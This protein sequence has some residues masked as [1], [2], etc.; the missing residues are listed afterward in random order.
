MT[1]R[2]QSLLSVGAW[3]LLSPV[4]HAQ[5]LALPPPPPAGVTQRLGAQLPLAMP[6]VDSEG[7]ALRLGALFGDGRP[8]L[9]VP[10]YYR[11]PQ[12]CGLVMHGLLESLR[13]AKVAAADV[14][15][16]GIS[17]DAE[18]TPATARTRRDA[19]LAYA[20]FLRGPGAPLADLRLLVAPAAQTQ[21]LARQA[22]FRY[23]GDASQGI[24]HAAAVIVA[25]PQ[26]R[27]SH[28]L[29]GV[30][31]DPGELRGAL[32]EASGGRVGSLSERIALLC[33]HFDPAVGR[34]SGPVMAALRVGG[35][36]LAA[37][38]AAW[39]WRRRAPPAGEL[40]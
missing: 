6:V 2:W 11:C 31:F 21:A 22:G 29:L 25:T 16:V 1:R 23:S 12:L 32:A 30:R 13:D 37:G 9:L 15:I 8:V 3:L 36:L 33:A 39:C 24:A 26:G 40:R 14:R 10:G 34:F 18:D 35:L 28:Y 19:D 20:Q 17:I 5:P 4:L 38:L 27:I 7:R